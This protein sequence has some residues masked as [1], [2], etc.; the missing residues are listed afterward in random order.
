MIDQET[1]KITTLNSGTEAALSAVTE[2]KLG[3]LVAVGEDGIHVIEADP[4]A[5]AA[6]P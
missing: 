4:D 5:A 6:A 3:H 1:G 2:V